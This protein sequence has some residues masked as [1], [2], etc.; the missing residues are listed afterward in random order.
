[1]NNPIAICMVSPYPPPYGGIAHWTAMLVDYTSRRSDID[2]TVVNTAPRWRPIHSAGL[3]LRIV[4]GG[5]QLLRDL[6]CLIRVLTA[7][8]YDAVHLTTSGQFGAVRDLAVSYVTSLFAIGLVYH[9]RF[10]R[11]PAIAE[12]GSLE[13]RLI[14]WVMRRATS[15]I[16]IDPATVAA[17]KLFAPDVRVV[18]VPNC[19]NVALLPSRA[20]VEN[21]TKTVLFVG[22][23]IPT[24][25]IHELLAAWEI[26]KTPGWRLEILGPCESE[27]QCKLMQ[28][29]N[30]EN[31]EFIG[32]LPH[33]Q[34][35]KRMAIC[36]LFVL[37][38]YTEGFPNSVAE[39]MALGRAIIGTDVGAI[40]EMLSDGAGLIVKNRN[41]EALAQALIKAMTDAKLRDSLGRNAYM[42]AMEQYTIEVVFQSYLTIWRDVPCSK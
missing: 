31:V 28:Q 35:M 15:V 25:G 27:Y 34:T 13:W 11:V 2:L 8:N 21:K 5:L 3:L 22:W 6:T 12:A 7:R 32:L 29:Y 1:M 26:A 38:S 19:V 37:P 4:S 20:T 17:V 41:H 24:K 33:A 16:A 39:A 18:L 23:V 14:R 42:K 36:D 30:T 40:P 9:I 10:G